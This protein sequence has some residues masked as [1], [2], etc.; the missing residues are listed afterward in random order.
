M[1]IFFAAFLTLETIPYPFGIIKEK[2]LTGKA[3]ID[4]GKGNE[5]CTKDFGVAF[6]IVSTSSKTTEINALWLL[7][8]Q[9]AGGD[10]TVYYAKSGYLDAGVEKTK[11]KELYKARMSFSYRGGMRIKLANP[12]SLKPGEICGIY[13]HCN[14]KSWDPSTCGVIFR[15]PTT[16][17]LKPPIPKDSNL[18]VAASGVRVSRAKSPFTLFDD[19]PEF[20]STMPIM[21]EYRSSSSKWPSFL[22]NEGCTDEAGF[23]QRYMGSTNGV[24]FLLTAKHRNVQVHGL[25]GMKVND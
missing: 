18:T 9:N 23:S 13:V 12:V 8:G 16:S 22:S 6:D 25:R 17:D 14:Y 19:T 10:V 4:G 7:M 20:S 24:G 3:F 11:W 21:I 1:N 5:N 15:W 2:G